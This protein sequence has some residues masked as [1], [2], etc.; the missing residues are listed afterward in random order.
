MQGDRIAPKWVANMWPPHGSHKFDI[1]IA[2]F[3]LQNSQNSH[4]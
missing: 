3:A 4:F 2:E 1:F